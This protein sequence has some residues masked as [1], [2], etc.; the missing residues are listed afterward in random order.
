VGS[1]PYKLERWDTGQEIVLVRN[2]FSWRP[3]PAVQRLS[4]RFIQEEQACIQAFLSGELDDVSLTPEWYARLKDSPD[5]GTRY[6]LYRYSTPAGSYRYIAWNNAKPQLADSRVRRAMTML[7]DR[8]AIIDRQLYG[9]ATAISGPF[10]PQSPQYDQSIRPWPYDKEAALALLKEAGW[11]DRKGNGW[12]E[13]ERGERLAFELAVPAGPQLSRD[14]ARVL[15]EGFREA[16]IEMN[17]RFYEWSV[18]VSRLGNRDYEA[19]L[20]GGAGSVEE[21]PYA[22]WHS[23]QIANRGA[24]HM[25]FRSAEADQLIEEARLTFDENQR[26]ALYHR[27]HRVLHEEQP[28]TFLWRS[29]SLRAFAP[30]VQGVKVHTLGLDDREWRIGKDN[31]GDA[32]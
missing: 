2:P 28:C 23:S 25:G 15:Q 29:D 1:G 9:L 24:N 7:I 27:F 31:S 22:M 3:A 19:A 11:Q 4:F 6:R 8:Q 5:N 18:L 17:P 10:W 32:L 30:R 16:G 20:L 14:I 12:L 26:Q 13:N 21:D